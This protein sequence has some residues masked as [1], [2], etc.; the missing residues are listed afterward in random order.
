MKTLLDVDPLTRTEV[1][2]HYDA[3]TDTTTIEEVQDVQ[4]YLEAAKRLR[5]DAGYSQKGIKDEMWH[6]AKIPNAIINKMMLEHGVNVFDKGQAKE[7][8]RL[9]NTHFP[10]LKTTTGTHA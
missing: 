4:P 2:H 10:A 9:I 8:I 7:V 1:W 3:D 5:N 6:Y